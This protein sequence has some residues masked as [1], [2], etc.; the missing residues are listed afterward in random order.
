M[1]LVKYAVLIGKSDH[2]SLRCAIKTDKPDRP[3]QIGKLDYWKGDYQAINQELEKLNW[4]SELEDLVMEGSWNKFH[5]EL[6]NLIKK[7]VPVKKPSRRKRKSE[8]SRETIK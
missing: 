4:E 7:D 6:L 8:W 1:E 2:V 5:K 3:T